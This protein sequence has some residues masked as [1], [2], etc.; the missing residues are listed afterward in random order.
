MKTYSVAPG[1]P[2]YPTPT[3]SFVIISK[4]VN[5]TWTPPNSPWA[6]GAVPIGPGTDDP[7]QARWMGLSTP[8]VG[9]HGT[10]EPWTVGTHASHG[11]IRMRVPDVKDL[12]NRVFIG[13]P[14]QIVN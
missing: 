13:T 4:V 12:F 6:A 2:A 9:I 8:G 14:V 7:L 11:C 1:R 3:G 10:N 5:P